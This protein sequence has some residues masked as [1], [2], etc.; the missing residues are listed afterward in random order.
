M[1]SKA[2]PAGIAE[3]PPC[4]LTHPSIINELLVALDPRRSCRQRDG[5]GVQA[6]SR[7]PGLGPEVEG[8][9]PKP[10]AGC[11]PCGTGALPPRSPHP[12]RATGPRVQPGEGAE[13]GQSR[14]R[15]QPLRQ[16]EPATL[17]VSG[18][19]R[20]LQG[21]GADEWGGET[22]PLEHLPAQAGGH[23]WGQA[24]S[25]AQEHRGAAPVPAEG[26][27]PRPP[28]PRKDAKA[29]GDG[30]DQQLAVALRIRPMSTA[31]LAEGARPVA[32]RVDEQV[33]LL[34]DPMED[35]DDVLRASRSREKSYVFD[36]AFDSTATQETVY[37]ATTRGLIAGV[38]SG[39]N[40]T[41]FAYGPTGCGK[42]Y[43]MLGTNGEP[44]ICTRTLGDLFQAIE[45]ASGDTEYKVSMS[46][47]EIYNEMV[48]DL[49]NPSLGCL[50]LREDASGTVRVAGITEV[51]AIDA[52]EVMQLLAR[53]NRQRTQE[54]TAANRTSSRSHAVLQVTVRQR[55]RGGG[56][57]RGR[58]F[59]VDLAG[60][61]RA[62]QTQNRGQRMKEG[63]HINRSLLALGNCIKALSDQASTKY[64]NYR[65]SKLTRLLKDSLGGNSRTVMIAHIS[66]ASTAFEESRSTLAYARRAKSIRT[67]VR[68]NLLSIS[69]HV[70]QYGSVVAD[71]RREI[72]R[73]KGR[74]N[75]EP[76]QPGQGECRDT[77]Y[78]QA[79]VPLRGARRT[80]PEPGRMRE[81]LLGACHE[82]A[83]LH[84][85]LQLEDTELH[86]QHL[87]TLARTRQSWQWSKEGLG[88]PDGPG[89]SE[90]DSDTGDKRLDVPEPPDVAAVHEGI[91]AL[92]EE[93]G[94]LQ[95]R[96]AELARRFRQSQQR[97]RW[98]EEALRHRSSSE[99]PREVLALLC[100]LHQLELETAETRSRALLEGGLRHLPA[101]AAQR[102]DRHRAL[103]ARII[104][105]QRQLIADHRL[106]VPRPLEELY[107]TYLR[108]L[109]GGPGDTG[110]L[111]GTSLPQIPQVTG[112]ESRPQAERD[113][114]WAQSCEHPT[115]P[116][117]DAL[118]PLRPTGDS[119]LTPVFKKTP[120][121]QQPGS[122]AV[123]TPPPGRG[124]VVQQHT[125]WASLSTRR[126]SCPG[127]GT[128]SEAAVATGRE[129]REMSSSTKSIVAKAAWHRSR[130]PESTPAC[131][132]ACLHSPGSAEERGGPGQWHAA[133]EDSPAGMAARSPGAR[134]RARKKGSKELGRSEE[135]LDGRRRS[136]RS[137]SFEVTGRGHG[138]SPKRRAC[139]PSLQQLVAPRGPPP[140]PNVLQ[141]CAEH[142]VP[143]GVQAAGTQGP[144]KALPG[145][146]PLPRKGQ[147]SRLGCVTGNGARAS[148]KD[149][150]NY[151][152]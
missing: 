20:H 128:S 16:R 30:K 40:A 94:R 49:L 124:T 150:G 83:A 46:Y 25:P 119:A 64:I 140:S 74:G 82:P 17:P 15:R 66:P 146:K 134:L 112:T 123:P 54:P 136:R 35:P 125:S 90:R 147:R 27:S 13:R 118:P 26:S 149:G 4:L 42:T 88:E 57:H 37:R 91:T 133:S 99:E 116:R 70:A 11:A 72:Q 106:S 114:V 138:S 115:A 73:L 110:T 55:R 9:F 92:V 19:A 43:T 101:T 113:S 39:Y 145:P 71:P 107:E 87:L 86:A 130:I 117:R 61:E 126:G 38:I 47:L 10:C 127:S 56:L 34:R 79:R 78:I 21:T 36:V 31:E 131:R 80:H 103:C 12:D 58:L 76:G 89:D 93:Q 6:A 142:A 143:A 121:A 141:S 122:A 33:V 75:T 77:P 120:R 32:H 24:H 69:Y 111:K 29:P 1:P 63:A 95:Q 85:L 68:H 2:P 148:G 135:S 48:R 108:E 7:V 105:Q 53:G 137:P 129:H 28:C 23:P 3:R 100:H 60:S 132:P 65:D 45:D 51:S 14:T 97:A 151:Q 62:A 98:L 50:Q 18:T 22:Q 52:E 84:H 67:T 139:G 81:E 8:H 44:G 102:F 96:K 5:A 144:P 109:A 41:V 152:Y 59:M 104:H